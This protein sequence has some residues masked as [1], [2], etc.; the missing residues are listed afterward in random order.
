[1]FPVYPL[2]CLCAAITVHLLPVSIYEPFHACIYVHYVLLACYAY[3][4][5]L[6][7]SL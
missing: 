4:I 7:V 3:S 5:N 2:Y 1:M 6:L